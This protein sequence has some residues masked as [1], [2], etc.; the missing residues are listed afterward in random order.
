MR[1]WDAIN[2]E[3]RTLCGISLLLLCTRRWSPTISRLWLWNGH[4]LVISG[5]LSR[6]WIWRADVT[7][8]CL[9]KTQWKHR[10]K[11]DHL[12]WMFSWSTRH[13][14][15]LQWPKLAVQSTCC[16]A[17]GPCHQTEELLRLSQPKLGNLRSENS[18]YGPALCQALLDLDK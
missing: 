5:T 12:K 3:M 15:E 7:Y 1:A 4:V 13:L 16:G 8:N 6:I 11:C 10:L 9:P 17:S 2:F 14:L 18:R